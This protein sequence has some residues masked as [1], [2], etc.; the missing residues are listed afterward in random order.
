M[1]ER[2]AELAGSQAWEL[3]DVPLLTELQTQLKPQFPTQALAVQAA[4]ERN[5]WYER[6]RGASLLVGIHI[7]AWLA[8]IF[9]YPRRPWVQSIFFW[10]K[11][12]R[13]FLGAGYVGA[14]ITLVPWLRRRMLL[15]FQAAFLPQGILEQ[16]SERAYFTDCEVLL[17][18]N[19]RTDPRR[20]QVKEALR[21]I[22][23]QVVLKGQSG[24]GK[25]LLLLRLALTAKEPVVFLRATECSDGV[26]AAIQ[27]K[28]QGQVRDTGY[29]RSLI[30]AG[31]LK[32][33]IDGLN[34]ASPDARAR[35]T[36]FVEEYFKGDFILTTQ[37][38]SWEPPATAR[39]YALQPLQPEQIKPFLLKQWEAI[40]SRATL[41]GAQYEAA[42]LRYVE[43]IG[44]D[45][46]A[47]DADARLLTLSNPMDA[48]LAAEL[49]ARGETPDP[50][51]L[52]EQRYRVMAEGFRER[53]GR[54]FQLTRFSERVYEWRK[55][56]EPDIST[57]GFEPEVAALVQDRLMIERT[58]VIRKEKGGEEV[59][60]W[61]FRHDKIMEFFLL[62]AF[63]GVDGVARRQEHSLDAQFWSVYELLATQLPDAEEGKLHQFLIEQAAD[64][65]RNDLLNRYTLARRL[66]TSARQSKPTELAPQPSAI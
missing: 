39:V 13:R 16:L 6:L 12:A 42:V 23:G 51:R 43:A 63:T 10:N 61:F 29:L 40:Q 53:E 57:E 50:F 35:I 28:V 30:Y 15:P 25:T 52:V 17:E 48:T 18:K 27:K 20:L 32:V 47:S 55:S 64:T 1:A 7:T 5:E 58:E 66:R 21:G 46:Q 37:P 45:S 59:S 33:L 11:W 22:R 14:L 65:N 4:L 54:D 31:G 24:L 60:R 3:K 9:A 41:D 62:R 38:I 34:E 2:I 8:L 44:K 56:G 26:I 19:R 49:L 36:Q